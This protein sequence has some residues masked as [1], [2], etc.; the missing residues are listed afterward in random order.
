MGKAY[1]L[2]VRPEINLHFPL[3]MPAIDRKST[4]L[5]SSHGYISYAVFCLKKKKKKHTRL[6]IWHSSKSSRRSTMSRLCRIST[7]ST[8][9]AM[10]ECP[11]ASASTMHDP[12]IPVCEHNS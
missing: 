5:N 9:T 10:T 2:H 12:R 3:E 7:D 11:R 8:C 6:R 1:Y 4:R